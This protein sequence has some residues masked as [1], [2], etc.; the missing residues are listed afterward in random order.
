[1]TQ[2]SLKYRF[3]TNLAI[4]RDQ[5]TIFVTMTRDNSSQELDGIVQ[6]FKVTSAKE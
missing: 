4:V 5:H 1:L 2:I 6:A 3:V